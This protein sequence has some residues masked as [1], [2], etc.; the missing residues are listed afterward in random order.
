MP[1]DRAQ[2]FAPQGAL[3]ALRNG[4]LLPTIEVM[5]SCVRVNI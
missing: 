1:S 2:A 4:F 5:T 3:Q